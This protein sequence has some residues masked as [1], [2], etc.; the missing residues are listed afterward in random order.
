PDAPYD[1]FYQDEVLADG[2][3]VSQSIRKMFAFVAVVTLLIAGTG[4]FAL[5]S[6]NIARRTKEIGIRKVLGA[7]TLHIGQLINRP[8]VAL[9]AATTLA[10]AASG[11]YAFDL[12]LGAIYTYHVAVGPVPFAVAALL[13]LV[14]ALLA[15]A[16]KVYRAASANPVHALRSE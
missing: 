12:L 8:F 1:G 11:Y 13:V 10:A 3:Q 6:L 16:G 2:V 9:V 15:V 4:L 14:L 5:V 7:S